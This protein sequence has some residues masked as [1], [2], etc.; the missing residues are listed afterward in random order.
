[1]KYASSGNET[2]VSGSSDY[3]ILLGIRDA[4]MKLKSDY[5]S[6]SG[7][8][9]IK[10]DDRSQFDKRFLLFE[11]ELDG[12]LRRRIEYSAKDFEGGTRNLDFTNL[13]NEK[14]NQI[15]ELEKKIQNLEERLRRASTREL[16]LESKISQLNAELLTAKDRSLTGQ[17]LDIAVQQQAEIERLT[18]DIETLQ[19][20]FA[21]AGSIWKNQVTQIRA[22]Y[23]SD[24]FDLDY[25][26]TNLLQ[27]T[28]VRTYNVSG[29]ET[30]EVRSEK[31]VEVPVQDVRTKSLLHVLAVN[32]KK[33]SS[34]YP[35]LL[36][37]FD[38]RLSEYFS[39]E[40]IDV[41]EVDEIDRIVEI[42]KF[43]PQAIRVEN[44]YAYSSAKSRR[45]EFHLRVLIKAL[46]EEL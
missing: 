17:K 28:N 38:S 43:V 39:Q 4:I 45:V 35:K 32:L 30:I 5:F 41:I 11:H 27:K 42:V 9:L 33:L 25:E 13:L 36:T 6:Q 21:A 23:P 34:K 20:N 24:R 18:R 1:M 46:L 12:L 44:V 19:A 26:I 31:T 22:K 3:G 16:E 10:G 7:S 40:L 8:I 15:V 29:I 37:E 2:V 14:E